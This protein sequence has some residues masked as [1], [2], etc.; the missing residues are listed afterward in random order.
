MSLTVSNNSFADIRFEI[1]LARLILRLV[2]LETVGFLD[3]HLIHRQ[4]GDS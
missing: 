1:V 2:T 4:I 3:T